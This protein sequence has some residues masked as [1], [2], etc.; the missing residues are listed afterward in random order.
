[1]KKIFCYFHND[2]MDGWAS[3][4]IVGLKHK[5]DNVEYHGYNYEPNLPLVDGYD[6][7]YMLD[8]SSI[9]Q[10]M[11][12]LIR[13]NKKFVWIDHHAKKIW[14][15]YEKIGEGIEGLRDTESNHSACVL[16]WNYLFGAKPLPEMLKYVEDLDIWKWKYP[17]TEPINTCLHN[18]FLGNRDLIIQ[19]M[20]DWEMDEKAIIDTGLIQLKMRKKQIEYILENLRTKTFHGHKTG[21]VNSPVHQSFIGHEMLEQNPDIDIAMIWYARKDLVTISL[22]SRGDVDVSKIASKY[23][24]GGHKPASGFSVK[25]GEKTDIYLR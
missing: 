2:D 9:W 13:N 4:A 20:G 15:T 23:G 16:T 25:L 12:Y 1:M 19:A 10:D 24:G 7:V 8:C 6:I 3:S 18:D 14:D 21:V 11:A 22:R 5:N 17:L